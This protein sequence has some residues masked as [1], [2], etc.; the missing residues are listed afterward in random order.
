MKTAAEKFRNLLQE[1]PHY[2][3]EVYNL[4]YETLDCISKRIVRK[5]EKTPQHVTIKELAGGFRLYIIEQFGCLAKTVLNEF[6]VR[7]TRDIGQAVFN[8]IEHDLL[9]KQEQ[10][11]RED[12]NNLYD[13]NKVFNLKPKFKYN[14]KTNEWETKYIQKR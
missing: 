14:P 3:K 13:F 2:D 1:C 10:D 5:E 9:G 12:F 8:L 11:R 4:I 6:G 7:T